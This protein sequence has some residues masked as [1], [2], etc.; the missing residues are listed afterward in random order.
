MVIDVRRSVRSPALAG[1]KSVRAEIRI[2][3]DIV[4]LYFGIQYSRTDIPVPVFYGNVQTSHNPLLHHDVRDIR[5]RHEPG[6]SLFVIHLERS[7]RIEIFTLQRPDWIVGERKP[8]IRHV[9]DRSDFR[10]VFCTVASYSQYQQNV[11][12]FLKA[13]HVDRGCFPV[14]DGFPS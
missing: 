10:T 1:I 9:T 5:D 13:F 4:K 14:I 7:G 2:E 8:H 12:T 11:F 6:R 3:P